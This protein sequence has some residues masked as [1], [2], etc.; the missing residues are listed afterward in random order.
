MILAF[1]LLVA[2]VALGVAIACK[3]TK[4]NEQEANENAFPNSKDTSK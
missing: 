3:Q 4:K 2:C 1:L